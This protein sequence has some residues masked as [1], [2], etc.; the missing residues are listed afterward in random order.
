MVFSNRK[1]EPKEINREELAEIVENMGGPEKILAEMN[2]FKKDIEFLESRSK[3]LIKKYPDHWVAVYEEKLVG[4]NKDFSA[5]FSELKKNE[6]PTNKTVIRFLS[7]K[8]IKII[9]FQQGAVA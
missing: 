2:Q 3:D 5:L 8:P 4:S 9:L 1:Q 6:I 7:T